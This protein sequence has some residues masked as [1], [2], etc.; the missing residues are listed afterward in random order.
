MLIL[1]D[2]NQPVGKILM[3]MRKREWR[4][5]SL[6]QPKDQFGN[7]N[8]TRFR[9]RARLHDGAIRWVGW[10]DDREDF[11]AFL[12]SLARHLAI[13]SPFPREEFNLFNETWGDPSIEPWLQY[14]FAT[15][16]FLTSPTGSNQTYTSPSDW[17]NS[18]NTIELIAGGAS[19]ASESAT[20]HVTGGGGGEYGTVSNFSFATPGTTTATYQIGAA[21]AA[22]NSNPSDRDGN[23]GG[24]SWFNGT[25][26][27]GATIGA[28]N[29]VKGVHGA[30][31]QNG[32]AGGTGG[33]GSSHTTGGRGG[34]LT[35]ASGSGASGGGG[36]AGPNGNGN[37]GGDSA[38]TGTDVETAG[39]SG[40]PGCLRLFEK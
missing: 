12:Y 14:D 31:S 16:T 27:A 21:G 2:K 19:G 11:D 7:E 4:T 39:G 36:A 32:G 3:P 23:N 30:G 35:G 17:N 13:G 29:G 24:A 9:I 15:V 26:Q 34:N 22:A 33:V 25:T 20:T 38:S 28:L 37:N 18:S 8:Q 10:F 40:D 5:P 6:T 1:P